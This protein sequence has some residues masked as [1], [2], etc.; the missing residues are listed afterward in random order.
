ML[1]TDSDVIFSFGLCLELC[2][3]SFKKKI[4]LLY[5]KQFTGLS[6]FFN[7]C[8]I[9]FIYFLFVSLNSHS[10]QVLMT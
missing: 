10:G 4:N 7:P 9:S 1:L 6:Y 5:I 8:L 3:V 2:Y